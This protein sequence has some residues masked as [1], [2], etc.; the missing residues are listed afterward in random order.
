MSL[1]FFSDLSFEQLYSLAFDAISS[2]AT[3]AAVVVVLLYVT[4]LRKCM[5][6]YGKKL[7]ANSLIYNDSP[8]R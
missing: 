6:D 2:L 3:A 8:K 4:P 1:H 7:Q 5:Y